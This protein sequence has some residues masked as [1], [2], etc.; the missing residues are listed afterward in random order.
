MAVRACRFLVALVAIVLVASNATT[1]RAD[2]A[3]KARELFTQ[4]NTYFDLGQFDK[5]IDT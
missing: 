4:G 1:A 2:D 5:A 3:Q